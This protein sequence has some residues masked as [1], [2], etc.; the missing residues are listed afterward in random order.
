MNKKSK[1]FTGVASLLLVGAAT[2]AVAAPVVAAPQ[3]VSASVCRQ[4]HTILPLMAA[5][6]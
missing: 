2:V 6:T 1:V 5:R 4:S 3:V